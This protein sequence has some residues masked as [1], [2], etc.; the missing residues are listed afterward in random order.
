MFVLLHIFVRA[1]SVS[2]HP[3]LNVVALFGVAN[4]H[5]SRSARLIAELHK[6]CNLLC[7][8]NFCLLRNTKFAYFSTSCVIYYV[9]LCVCLF[10]DGRAKS[11]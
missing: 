4:N 9:Q 6:K 3:D 1:L 2:V 10:L 11:R 7:T 5:Y 8:F